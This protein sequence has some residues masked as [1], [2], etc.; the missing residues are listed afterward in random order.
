MFNT[1]NQPLAF[2][3][4]PG[5]NE[6]R[7]CDNVKDFY[8]QVA[9]T[10]YRYPI[11]FGN[12]GHLQ[13]IEG[14]VHMLEST[15]DTLLL[16]YKR[17]SRSGGTGDDK[18]LLLEKYFS[19]NIFDFFPPIPRRNRYS[20]R[21]ELF[22]DV[23]S[24]NIQT[25]QS[26]GAGLGR[27]I[28][29]N[30]PLNVPYI[31]GVNAV[32]KEIRRRAKAPEFRKLVARGTEKRKR[33]LLG[34]QHLVDKLFEKHARLLV[35]R[36]DLSYGAET[37]AENSAKSEQ[38]PG[39]DVEMALRHRERLMNAMRHKTK[40]FK[41]CVGYITKLEQGQLGNSHLHTIFFFDGS[42]VKSDFYYAKE[43]GDYWVNTITEKKGRYHNC[44]Q[45][46]SN[47]NKNRGIGMIRHDESDRIHELK[48]TVLPYL[49]KEPQMVL[50]TPI[51]R[52]ATITHSNLPAYLGVNKMGRKRKS[53]EK[54]AAPKPSP[55]PQAPGTRH[56]ATLIIDN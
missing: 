5:L 2:S 3:H 45:N 23:M 47:P 9:I 25:L 4:P 30:N 16:P 46:N 42:H 50:I 19:H 7:F 20:R 13:Q 24:E 12:I 48:C 51:K 49:A 34:M 8:D 15:D 18:S 33:Q 36:V 1:N 6:Q 43:I 11:I 28:S 39:A 17:I 14:F 38:N 29:Y 40:V 55:L 54:I 26:T 31:D 53:R 10:G 21:V 22:F 44:H 56:Q 52:I 32:I 37:H 27:W 35:V 41:H